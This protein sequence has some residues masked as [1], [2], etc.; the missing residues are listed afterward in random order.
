MVERGDD[1]EPHYAK[2]TNRKFTP[3]IRRSMAQFLAQ[4]PR[5]SSFWLADQL[6]Q[7]WGMKFSSAGVRKVLREMGYTH[8]VPKHTN[9][10]AEK[11]SG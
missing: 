4:N 2:T 7:R 9:L 5:K 10:T 11:Q 3:Q 1:M 8:S 6:K